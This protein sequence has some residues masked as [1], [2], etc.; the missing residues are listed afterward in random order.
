M[1]TDD[2][3]EEAP[4]VFANGK[5]YII[6]EIDEGKI[7]LMSAS[8]KEAYVQAYQDY[9]SVEDEWSSFLKSILYFDIYLDIIFLFL[10]HVYFDNF[11]RI[12]GF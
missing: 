4:T 11:L 5:A 1:E 10:I 3:D 12:C 8:E 7:A 6:T 9:Y 2:E